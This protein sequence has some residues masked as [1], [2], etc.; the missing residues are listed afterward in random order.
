MWRLGK[1]NKW[2]FTIYIFHYA[3]F[4]KFVLIELIVGTVLYY[5]LKELFL[6]ECIAVIG[7]I[8]GLETIKRLIKKGSRK[9]F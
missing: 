5:G 4:K 2:P 6:Y 1:K 3:D 8:I 9:R 7:S